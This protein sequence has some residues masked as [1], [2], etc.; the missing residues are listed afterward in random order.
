VDV[1][2]P[3]EPLLVASC[4]TSGKGAR[5]RVDGQT[6]YLGVI[7]PGDES[8]LDVIDISLTFDTRSMFSL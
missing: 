6:A 3:T 7:T 4:A 5:I 2:N 8:A 1:R